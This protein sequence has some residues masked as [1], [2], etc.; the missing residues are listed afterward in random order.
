MAILLIF[1]LGIIEPPGKPLAKD[2]N[3]HHK[4]VK[5]IAMISIV[6]KKENPLK[7]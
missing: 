1:L 7:K 6:Q 5:S 2:G 4:P 3:Q